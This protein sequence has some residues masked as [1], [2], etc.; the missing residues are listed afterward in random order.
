MIRTAIILSM[1]TGTAAQALTPL[2]P[3]VGMEAGMNTYD[4][5]PLDPGQD[6][7]LSFP[8]TED[9]LA[10]TQVWQ[11]GPSLI[12]AAKG[13]PEAIAALCRLGP[14]ARTAVTSQVNAMAGQGPCDGGC[15]SAT[16]VEGHA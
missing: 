6:L 14:V 12:A 15:C 16:D 4:L 8:L 3:C 10:M 1:L 11:K 2:P 7:V 9:L 5:Y 13:A